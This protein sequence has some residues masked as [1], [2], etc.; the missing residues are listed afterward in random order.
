MLLSL[1]QH[2]IVKTLEFHCEGSEAK[3]LDVVCALIKKYKLQDA[4][5]GYC[6]AST[7]PMPRCR[8]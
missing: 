2:G 4:V 3:L 5:A 8:S 6:G 1:E 7:E